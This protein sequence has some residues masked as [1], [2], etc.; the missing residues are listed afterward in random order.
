MTCQELADFLMNYLD[1]ELPEA[2]RASLAEH[3]ELCPPCLAYLRTYERT[4]EL[5]R[6]ICSDPGGSLPDDVPEELVRAI[7][8]ARSPK[9]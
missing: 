8:T 5:G 4:V 1:G 2:Q 3:L 6:S 9:A 7:L